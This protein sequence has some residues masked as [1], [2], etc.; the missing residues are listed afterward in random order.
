MVRAPRISQN[1]S[2]YNLINSFQLEKLLIYCWIESLLT[3]T[4]PFIG[5]P[6]TDKTSKTILKHPFV[7]NIV[8]FAVLDVI[9]DKYR[10][11]DG[12][13]PDGSRSDVRYEPL[14][15]SQR[16]PLI[17]EVQRTDDDNF[18]A[19]ATHYCVMTYRRYRVFPVLLVSLSNMY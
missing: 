3:S 2:L 11:G 18:T 6:G 15:S 8:T 17:I 14:D 13:W 5:R 7:K 16:S 10:V 19:R 1:V 9:G 12:E 4:I